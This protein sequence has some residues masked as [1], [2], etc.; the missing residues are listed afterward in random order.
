MNESN[1]APKEVRP[2]LNKETQGRILAYLR[3]EGLH[4]KI[5]QTEENLY[6]IGQYSHY[7]RSL[8]TS[9]CS[10]PGRH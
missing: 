1:T 6:A 2:T 7:K 4:P 9:N 8:W 3:E 10:K 5:I